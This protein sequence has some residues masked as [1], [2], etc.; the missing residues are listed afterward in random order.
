MQDLYNSKCFPASHCLP[1]HVCTALL[2]SV[3]YNQKASTPSSPP[4]P[5]SPPS[6]AAGS[7]CD[8]KLTDCTA[9]PCAPG[10]MK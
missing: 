7:Q 8:A 2:S 9:L 4:P 10:L 1:V 3:A 6:Q 5:P